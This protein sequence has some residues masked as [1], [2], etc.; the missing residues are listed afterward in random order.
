MYSRIG[1]HCTATIGPAANTFGCLEATIFAL[2]EWVVRRLF[3]RFMF[4][5]LLILLSSNKYRTFSPNLPFFSFI[6]LAISK[7][8]VL[9][10]APNERDRKKSI[11]VASI[12]S[13]CTL[14]MNTQDMFPEI[15]QL[16]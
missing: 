16:I 11:K 4:N 8:D 12:L 7:S 14:K 2:G 15:E 3:P 6:F 9:T 13:F 1:R 5:D 10:E